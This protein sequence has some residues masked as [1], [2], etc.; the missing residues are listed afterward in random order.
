MN[1]TVGSGVSR[2]FSFEKS[3]AGVLVD[4][5]LR[6]CPLNNHSQIAAL[7]R[8]MQSRTLE[9]LLNAW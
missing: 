3:A 8:N 1:D 7:P 6:G 4:Y 2:T 9:L 5:E